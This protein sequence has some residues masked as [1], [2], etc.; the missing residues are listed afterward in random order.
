MSPNKAVG[1]DLYKPLIE[2]WRMVKSNPEK[3][4]SEYEKRW[5]LLQQKGYK[6]FYVVREHFNTTK[7]L[8]DLLFLSRTCVNGLIRFNKSGEFNN[9]L[10]HSRKG[11]SPQ[12]FKKIINEWSQIISKYSF[13][14]GDYEQVTNNAKAGDFIYLDPPYFNTKSRYIESID[15]ER[16]VQYLEKI[17]KKGIKFALSYD[18][19]RGDK[20]YIVALPKKLY[21]RHIMLKS[22]NSSFRK[23][24]DKKIETVLE[25]LYLN[26]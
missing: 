13:L 6:Y 2:I 12:S 19:T 8:H 5:E 1:G 15:Y 26:Y 14:S 4:A 18:G 23:L 7:N 11:I 16:F 25:S 17:N 20:S 22:G 3:V 9:S 24:Q 21:K 10:H